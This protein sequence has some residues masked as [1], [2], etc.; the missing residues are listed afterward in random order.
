MS[1]FTGVNS[2]K[3]ENTFSVYPNPVKNTLTIKL[4]N[5]LNP[6][7]VKL[8]NSNGV[9]VKNIKQ[10]GVQFDLGDLTAGIYFIELIADKKRTIKKIIKN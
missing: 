2:L 8:Y 6:T 4:L 7:A 3:N 9:L 10:Q 1:T 5:K